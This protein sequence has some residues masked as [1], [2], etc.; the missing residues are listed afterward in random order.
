MPHNSRDSLPKS[1]N[2]YKGHI[3]PKEPLLEVQ[4]KKWSA[5]LKEAL[6]SLKT[7]SK[8]KDLNEIVDKGRGKI[9][10]ILR[11]DEKRERIRGILSKDKN[12]ERR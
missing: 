1:P 8:K 10:R 12:L 5:L 4:A 9:C 6:V 2:Y 3:K 11:E 7:A